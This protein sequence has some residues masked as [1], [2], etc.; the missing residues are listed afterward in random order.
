MCDNS[1]KTEQ[2]FPIKASVIYYTNQG[3]SQGYKIDQDLHHS[4]MK[5]LYA[6]LHATMS[7]VDRQ[8]NLEITFKDLHNIALYVWTLAL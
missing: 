6:M 8:Y 5:L 4:I 3:G 7:G 1:N 2:N